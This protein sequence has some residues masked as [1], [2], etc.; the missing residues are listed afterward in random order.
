MAGSSVVAS[1]DELIEVL[2]SGVGEVE[3]RGTLSAIPMITL[4][5]GVRPIGRTDTRFRASAA[6]S[7]AASTCAIGCWPRV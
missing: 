7:I 5:P 4:A 3:V 1:V 6:T 2:R